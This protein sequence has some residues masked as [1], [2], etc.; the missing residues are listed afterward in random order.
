[1]KNLFDKLKE[2]RDKSIVQLSFTKKCKHFWI[3]Y[4]ETTIIT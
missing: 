3:P 2:L 4:Y 1:M